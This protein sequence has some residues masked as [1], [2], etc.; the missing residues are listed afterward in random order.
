MDMNLFE[1]LG[2]E[3]PIE[4]EVKVVKTAKKEKG[5]KKNTEQKTKKKFKLP[6]NITIPYCDS[7]LFSIDG[8]DSV[9]ESELKKEILTRYPW[10]VSLGNV[11]GDDPYIIY[12][13]RQHAIAKG[14][15][16]G[17]HL[18]YGEIEI[19]LLSEDGDDKTEWEIEE[20]TK[21]L[22][23]ADEELTDIPVSFISSNDVIVPVFSGDDFTEG[24]K[25]PAMTV[26]YPGVT[27]YIAKPKEDA[28]VITPTDVLAVLPVDIAKLFK[29]LL[30][31]RN[32]LYSCIMVPNIT[33]AKK[34]SDKKTSGFDISSG[35]VKVSLVYTKLDVKPDDF[36]GKNIIS[37]DEL[38]GFICK[39]GYPEFSPKRTTIEKITDGLLVAILKSSTKGGFAI[40]NY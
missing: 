28:D 13:E 1:M 6:V 35:N 10:C 14:S 38:C 40:E 33:S 39:S 7:L 27:N 34:T 29:P 5:E 25:Q 19:P 37:S 8:K 20:L 36:D 23:E 2:L 11:N 18:L 21:A 12:Y 17:E 4:D 9:T 24:I 32:E 16:A 22:Y 26:I 15:I 3:N 31:K 30:V